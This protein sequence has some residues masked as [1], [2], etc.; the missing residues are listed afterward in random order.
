MTTP[1]ASSA[2]ED[3][4]PM[5]SGAMMALL[6]ELGIE[7]TLHEH[8][9]LYTV[10][11]S[12]KLR[13]NLTGAHIKNLYLR[14][15]KK[16]NFLVVAE[17]NKVLDLKSLSGV[18]GSNRLSFGSGERLMEFLGVRAG[19]VSPLA[20]I[21]DSDNRVQLVIDKQILKAE[22]VNLHPLVNDKTLNI[23]SE[24][25]RQFLSHSKH[26]DERIEI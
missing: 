8:P 9:P 26:W 7:Y 19:A 11:D 24:G 5:S 1:D 21:N 16:R 18:V 2:F 6:D 15:N 14:D 10:A 12:Q 3:S 20:L 23:S 17:E 13:G 22:T 25:L 4:L